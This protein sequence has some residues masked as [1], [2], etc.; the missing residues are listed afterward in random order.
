MIKKMLGYIDIKITMGLL[1]RIELVMVFTQGQIV[2]REHKFWTNPF[3]TPN[4][5]IIIDQW[6]LKPSQSLSSST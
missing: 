1:S 6:F 4:I 5:R 2:K 3:P